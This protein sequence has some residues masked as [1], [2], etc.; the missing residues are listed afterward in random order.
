MRETNLYHLLTEHPLIT[1]VV[2]AVLLMGTVFI[3]LIK[4]QER[5]ERRRRQ[6]EEKKK[7]PK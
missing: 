2:C 7:E 4:F 1:F 3:V 5:R 6:E